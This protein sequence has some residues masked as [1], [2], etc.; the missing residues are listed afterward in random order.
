MQDFMEKFKLTMCHKDD[1][2]E[3]TIPDCGKSFNRGMKLSLFIAS[4]VADD[5]NSL[6]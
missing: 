5:K 4:S 2:F 1:G 3:L 6:I